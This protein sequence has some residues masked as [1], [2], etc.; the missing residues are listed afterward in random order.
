MLFLFL[1]DGTYFTRLTLLEVIQ[2]ILAWF[3]ILI[4]IPSEEQRRWAILHE[5]NTFGGDPKCSRVVSHA[6]ND[7]IR[8]ARAI[9]NST[10]NQSFQLR[11]K[12]LGYCNE[13]TPPSIYRTNHVKSCSSG[14]CIQNIKP[15]TLRKEHIYHARQ[16]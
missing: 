14:C 16:G 7:I 4:M 2:N 13:N 15:I 5:I 11:D 1:I 12:I 9:K 8:G 10:T 3:P 6:H